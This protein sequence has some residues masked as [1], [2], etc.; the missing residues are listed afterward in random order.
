MSILNITLSQRLSPEDGELTSP[1]VRVMIFSIL[2]RRLTHF[3]QS[4]RLAHIT[5]NPEIPRFTQSRRLVHSRRQRLECISCNVTL[6]QGW[7][8][9]PGDR[10]FFVSPGAGGWLIPVTQIG[11]KAYEMS[12]G[13]GVQLITKSRR[14][15]RVTQS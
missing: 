2:S 12:P 1:Q 14:L 13:A 9:S 8:V 15:A 7:L 10:V 6:S 11:R 4:Q 3:T 5:K